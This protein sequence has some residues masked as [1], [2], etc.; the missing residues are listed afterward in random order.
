MTL[1]A[2]K[3]LFR[4]FAEELF[5]QFP[6]GQLESHVHGGTENISCKI[7]LTGDE[8]DIAGKSGLQLPQ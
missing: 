4:G 5:L 3:A 1:E 8:L 6:G 7:V 2:D